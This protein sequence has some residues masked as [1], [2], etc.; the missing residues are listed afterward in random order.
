MNK[1]KHLLAGAL[2]ASLGL[3]TGASAT[4]YDFTLGNLKLW[5]TTSGRTEVTDYSTINAA[6]TYEAS[7]DVSVVVSN[8]SANQVGFGGAGFNINLGTL[9]PAANA[10]AQDTSVNWLASDTVS[11]NFDGGTANDLQDMGMVVG[12]GVVTTSATLGTAS[13]AFDPNA[14]ASTVT[15]GSI[16][17]GTVSDTDQVGQIVSVTDDT[18]LTI[19]FNAF[20]KGDA[21]QDGVVDNLDLKPFVEDVIGG[22]SNLAI[23]DINDDGAIDNLDLK[24]GVEYIIAGGA[25]AVASIPEPASIAMLGL[26]GLAML[27]RRK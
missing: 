17:A 12:A 18:S 7:F 27:R 8:L 26:G 25:A 11:G 13:V 16:L 14:A 9:A 2:L 23:Y 22:A 24:P 5:D 10:W 6:N 20:L 15:L 3:A 19:E 1:R 21:N 4:D